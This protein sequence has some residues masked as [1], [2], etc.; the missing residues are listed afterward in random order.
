MSHPNI[1][2]MGFLSRKKKNREPAVAEET[3]PLEEELQRMEEAVPERPVNDFPGDDFD[4]RASRDDFDGPAPRDGFDAGSPAAGPVADERTSSSRA[5]GEVRP[6]APPAEG[7]VAADAD[8][9]GAGR[10]EEARDGVPPV[11]RPRDEA[12]APAAP[13]EPRVEPAAERAVEEDDD[14]SGDGR[15]KAIDLIAPTRLDFLKPQEAQSEQPVKT[16]DVIA[17]ANQKGGVAKT[18]TTLNLAVAFA[19]SGYRVLCVD[20]DPQGNLTMSQGID[21]DKVENSLYDVLVNDLPIS[22]IILER[23]IDIAVASIDLA[24]AEIAMSTKIGRERSLEKALKEVGADYDFVCIDTPPSLGLLTI[25][26][27]TAA[28][29]VIVPVQCEYLSMRGLVQLQNTLRMIQ[30]NLNPDVHIEG[31]LPTMLDTRTIHAKEAV[32][33]LEENFGDLVFQSRIRKAI[34]FAEAPVKGSSVLKYDS[35]SSAANYYRELAKE[36]LANGSA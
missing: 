11:E 24:G 35:D 15:M 17:F 10:T 20:L 5:A 3:H 27:L 2:A 1:R 13:A 34:K 36:V 23:E 12:A 16:A 25:N 31:I 7:E 32:E 4:E 6:S 29:K 21:P 8:G 26:A 33:I 28:N 9:L 19:E 14:E 30:E 18:T 22:E